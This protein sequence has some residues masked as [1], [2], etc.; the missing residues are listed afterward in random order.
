MNPFEPF[1]PVPDSEP[2]LET[3][4]PLAASTNF[5]ASVAGTLTYVD[6]VDMLRRTGR[7]TGMSGGT[8]Y[9]RDPQLVTPYYW[10]DYVI[11]ARG[12]SVS[13]ALG[14]GGCPGVLTIYG[15]S[16]D[17]AT[18]G[19][20]IPVAGHVLYSIPYPGPVRLVADLHATGSIT[21]DVWGSVKARSRM[22]A[23]QYR[24]LGVAQTVFEL[25][26]FLRPWE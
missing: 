23:V 24:N 2:I 13:A 14:P 8:G 16:L 9:T 26:V 5:P 1:K 4:V 21:P 12:A 18:G 22:L 25:G 6:T 11:Y 10:I 7:D 3:D 15:G 20:N 17:V 19:V